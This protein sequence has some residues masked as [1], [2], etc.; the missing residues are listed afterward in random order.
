MITNT[1]EYVDIL[2]KLK[3]SPEQFL[4]CML[5]N[6]K[7]MAS[8]IKYVD[9]NKEHKFKHEQIDDLVDRGFLVRLGIRKPNPSMDVIGHKAYVSDYNID[10]FAVTHIFASNFL[11]DGEDAGNEFWAAY[12]SWLKVK[13]QKVSAK[14]CDK[15]D[16]ADKYAKK[17]KGSKKKHK[18]IMDIVHEYS[19]RNDG[20]ALMGI[21]KFVGSEQWDI[22]YLEYEDAGEGDIVN[23]I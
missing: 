3:I 4:I 22:L 12:P 13:N 6:D 21:E 17:I 8:A 11:I 16:L 7:D 2:C 15:D 20:Y 10:C 5:I 1:K 23:N 18:F 9:Q 19:R 14:S